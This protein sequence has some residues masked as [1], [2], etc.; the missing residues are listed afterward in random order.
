MYSKIDFKKFMTVDGVDNLDLSVLNVVNRPLKESGLTDWLLNYKNTLSSEVGEKEKELMASVVS[1]ICYSMNV[2]SFNILK[3]KIFKSLKN[4]KNEC[5]FNVIFNC[6]KELGVY[7]GGGY[8]LSSRLYYRDTEHNDFIFDFHSEKIIEVKS[9]NDVRTV[10]QVYNGV[11]VIE[12][13]YDSDRWYG[14]AEAEDADIYVDDSIYDYY[15]SC[16]WCGEW[17]ENNVYHPPVTYI[18]RLGCICECCAHRRGWYKCESCGEWCNDGAQLAEC[19]GSYDEGDYLCYSCGYDEGF[20]L[21]ECGEWVEFNENEGT[22]PYDLLNRRD[23]YGS[24]TPIG[25]FEYGTI[26]KDVHT[27]K[28]YCEQ[29]QLIGVEIETI[30]NSYNYNDDAVKYLVDKIDENI[31]DLKEDS[32]L[33]G[34]APS[35]FVT[36]AL[37]NIFDNKAVDSFFGGLVENIKDAGFTTN[38]SCGMHI[39]LDLGG[40]VG[41]W[42][43]LLFTILLQN[44]DDSILC[45]LFGRAPSEWCKKFDNNTVEY[46]IEKRAEGLEGDLDILRNLNSGSHGYMINITRYGTLEVR[47][48]A[49]SVEYDVIIKRIKVLKNIL[50]LTAGMSIKQAKKGLRLDDFIF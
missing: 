43:L 20:E 4:K 38:S 40:S 9:Y 44:T 33:S 30:H 36:R 15:E 21:N 7:Y 50:N 8:N 18:D 28:K 6:L 23:G 29:R 48:F 5:I 24:S 1:S 49:S 17:F 2:D 25:V 26:H 31:I 34:G 42:R 12:F 45:E 13:A 10:V 16:E 11:K 35:E 19:L 41:A 37:V 47:L 3:N 27:N 22:L 39:H 32:S 14:M 46:Y